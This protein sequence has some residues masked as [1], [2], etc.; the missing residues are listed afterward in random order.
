M[1]VANGIRFGDG[2]SQGL[3]ILAVVNGDS[4]WL[5]FFVVVF[6][7]GAVVFMSCA[8]Y[9]VYLTI[10]SGGRT[11]AE[12]LA[13]GQ[14]SIVAMIWGA[15]AV[16]AVFAFAGIVA[17]VVLGVPMI[18]MGVVSSNWD[19]T[20]GIIEVSQIHAESQASRNRKGP[21]PSRYWIYTPQVVYR[22]EID[23]RSY[24]SD[25]IAAGVV[26]AHTEVGPVK[27]F[28]AKYPVGNEVTVH[29]DQSNPTLALLEPGVSWRT[30]VIP[31]FGI[32]L[33][34]AAAGAIY[35]FGRMPKPG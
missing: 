10:F 14:K 30:L 17:V 21:G 34:I 35:F 29:Y 9:C 22:Y 25:R 4:A 26:A 15:R 28:L 3:E 12:Q 1:K 7:I 2:T 6:V 13:A 19:T 11:R 18:A 20:T 24:T 23:G 33:L 8:L 27:K 31:L 32:A 16:A 5:P